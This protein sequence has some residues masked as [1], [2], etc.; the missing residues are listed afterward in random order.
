MI[1][2]SATTTL[3]CRACKWRPIWR[4]TFVSYPLPQ[5]WFYYQRRP[6]VQI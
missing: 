5:R 2:K 4:P 1:I 6:S 3:F